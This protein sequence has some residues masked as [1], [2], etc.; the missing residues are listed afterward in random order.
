MME[1][2]KITVKFH[3][4]FV[5]LLVL[6]NHNWHINFAKTHFNLIRKGRFIAK[7]L[8]QFIQADIC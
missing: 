4:F 6:K 7:V 2:L 5:C 3:R 8:N 1:V